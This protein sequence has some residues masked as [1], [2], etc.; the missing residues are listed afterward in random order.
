[1]KTQSE[2]KKFREDIKHNV[3]VRQT[4]LK[5]TTIKYNE[6]KCVDY[7]YEEKQTNKPSKKLTANFKSSTE[8]NIL[9][10]EGKVTLLS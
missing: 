8:G 3:E 6:G 7:Q 4:T 9:D 2:T 10:D 5:I 1:M